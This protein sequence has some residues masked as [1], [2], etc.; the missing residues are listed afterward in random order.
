[1]RAY[2]RLDPNFAD[3]KAD[4]PDGAHR[5]YIDTLCFAEQQEP[6]GRFRSRKLLAVLLEKRA[7]WITYLVQ[8]G[9]LIETPTGQLVVDG[10]E[11]WQEGDWKVHERVQRIR[12]RK[13]QEDTAPTVTPDTPATVTPDTVEPVITPHSGGG[14]SGGKPS[15]E[16]ARRKNGPPNFMGFRPKDPKTLTADE[17]ASFRRHA[18]S[19]ADPLIRKNARETLI[20]AGIEV[21]T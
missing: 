2:L 4:Y 8:H 10:W 16:A 17:I 15:A 21:P 19:S 7:R 1:M 13:R 11:E 3:R 9:D 18:E 5:A 20:R 6:R 12:N 14:G